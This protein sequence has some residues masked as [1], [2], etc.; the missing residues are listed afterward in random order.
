MYYHDL[1]VFLYFPNILTNIVFLHPQAIFER[2]SDFIGISLADAVDCL[3]EECINLYEPGVH[4]ELKVQGTFDKNFLTLPNSH[5]SQGFFSGFT[6]KDFLKL[7]TSLFIFTS[8]P[9]QG[10]YF[11]LS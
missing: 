4:E 1:T 7:M 9:E 5:L 8:L 11:I 2:L 6:V 10:K 3:E